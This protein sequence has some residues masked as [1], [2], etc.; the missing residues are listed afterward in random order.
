[1]N[2]R[3]QTF[4]TAI[5]TAVALGMAGTVIVDRVHPKAAGAGGLAVTTAG[6]VD[7]WDELVNSPLRMGPADAK[8][9]IVEFADF[10]CPA[11]RGFT[12]GALR[13]IRAEYPGDVAIFFHHWP[14]SYHRFAYP[15]AKAAECANHQARFEQFHD[16]VYAHQDSLGLITFIEFARIAGVPDT[17]AFQACI[18]QPGRVARVDQ[19]AAL[20]LAAGGA[21]TPTVLVNGQRLGGVPDSQAL[22][23]YVATLLATP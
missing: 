3:L 9:K 10:E 16:A 20:A 6:S 1:M 22:S 13:G 21:G 12:T 14:L 5:C 4:F 23:N 17:V 7:N 8:V 2:D 11:C 19:D 18:R 15:A